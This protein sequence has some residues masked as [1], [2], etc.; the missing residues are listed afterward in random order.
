MFTTLEV[1]AKFIV[2]SVLQSGIL[3]VAE[4]WHSVMVH[5]AETSQSVYCHLELS[6]ETRVVYQMQVTCEVD[7][8][9]MV[10]NQYN[11]ILTSGFR[12][13]MQREHKQLR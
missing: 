2:F 10:R 11:P 3:N 13:Q 4:Y 7:E 6:T 8:K 1:V 5:V 12:H 9:A